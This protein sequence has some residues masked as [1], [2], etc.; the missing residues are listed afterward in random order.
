MIRPVGKHSAPVV[1]LVLAIALAA[2]GLFCL[3][4]CYCAAQTT[5]VA[6]TAGHE[7]GTLILA[8]KIALCFVDFQ[9]DLREQFL[10]V[11]AV[12]AGRHGTSVKWVVVTSENPDKLKAALKGGNTSA[13]VI[14]DLGGR[15]LDEFG[16]TEVPA[17]IL[18]SEGQIIYE[19]EKYTPLHNERLIE[20]VSCFARG[21]EIP[22]AYLDS[23]LRVGDF[24]PDITLPDVSGKTWSLKLYRKTKNAHSRLLYVFTIMNCEPCREALK[25]LKENAHNLDDT[26]VVVI[27]FGPKKLTMR[28]L[29]RT[30]LPFIVLCDESSETYTGYHL[31]DTPTIVL[32]CDDIITYISSGWDGNKQQELLQAIIGLQ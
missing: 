3:K 12:L 14:H 6:Q 31:S 30:P 1:I 13:E 19:S 4:P 27:S 16:V 21:Q 10:D 5:R 17:L 7:S 20:I 23:R 32:T 15:I 8:P 25:F 11:I 18:T 28:E 22:K 26:E 24:A 2:M 9:C 29:D